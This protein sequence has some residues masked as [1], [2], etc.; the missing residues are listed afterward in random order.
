MRTKRLGRSFYAQPTHEVARGLLGKL[1]VRNID[2]QVMRGRI[3]EVECYVGQDDMACHAAKGRTARTEA[4]FKQ[5]GFTYVYMI[6]GMYYCLNI[7]TEKADFPAAVLVRALEPAD[8]VSGSTNGPGKLCRALQI[9]K[10]LNGEDLVK[11]QHLWVVDDGYVL[12]EKQVATSKRIGVEYA[13]KSADL[14]WR[15]YIADS[16]F[17]SRHG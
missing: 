12:L 16:P 5:A 9:T 17:V 1:L 7:V 2:G 10:E 15:Y 14:P 3:V 8:N 13:G 4:M 11:S 6:Y